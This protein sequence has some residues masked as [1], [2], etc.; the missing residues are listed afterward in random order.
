MYFLQI[1]LWNSIWVTEGHFSKLNQLQ[2]NPHIN[3][4][5]LIFTSFSALLKRD[6]VKMIFFGWERKKREKSVEI[7]SFHFLEV[8]CCLTL[9]QD[10][11]TW[12]VKWSFCTFHLQSKYHLKMK[13]KNP[14]SVKYRAVFW[15][16]VC[17]VMV[18]YMCGKWFS[19][20]SRLKLGFEGGGRR[21]SVRCWSNDHC[22]P[23]F[24][25]KKK[26]RPHKDGQCKSSSYNLELMLFW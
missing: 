20:I 8:G 7:K 13:S 23:V 16:S 15:M 26:H 24:A 18:I 22:R 10:W 9:W 12:R 14:A 25:F 19:G 6:T 1:H 5:Q 3:V 2:Q 17:T 4:S 11:K 21:V